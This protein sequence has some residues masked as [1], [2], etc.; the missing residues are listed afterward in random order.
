MTI[1][2]ILVFLV[3]LF[4][5]YSAFEIVCDRVAESPKQSTVVF[6]LILYLFAIAIPTFALGLILW[7]RISDI[8]SP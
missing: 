6:F 1:F 8:L 2:L 3:M 4:L 5:L 7:K